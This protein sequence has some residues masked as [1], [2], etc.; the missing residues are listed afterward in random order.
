[1]DA[2]TSHR[3]KTIVAFAALYLIWGSTYL[4]IR[5][6]IESIPPF[7]LA[8]VRFL[9]SGPILLFV[10][11]LFGGKFPSSYCEYRNAAFVGLLLLLCGNGGVVWSQQYVESG[12][13]S[14]LVAT[15]PFFLVGIEFVWK[16]GERPGWLGLTG[17][18]VGFI[19]VLFLML[20]D[21]KGGFEKTQSGNSRLVG[22]VVLIVIAATWAFGSVFARHSRMPQDSFISTGLQMMFG[23]TALMIASAIHG[24]FAQFQLAQVTQNSIWA[25]VYLIVFGS[26]IGFTSYTWLLKNVPAAK[27]ATYAYV[28]PVV[29]VFLG[30]M[31]VDEVFTAITAVGMAV[32]LAGVVM[33]SQDKIRRSV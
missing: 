23:G 17:V 5:I 26:C 11:K 12:L 24:E 4:G 15:M 28:N 32:I 21:L 19:G 1:M 16:K 7:M 2:Q 27:V 22:E 20:P 30:W 10:G 6:G 13:A 25:L 8:G 31:F 3:W 33:V 29:A 14:L 18:C 9:I